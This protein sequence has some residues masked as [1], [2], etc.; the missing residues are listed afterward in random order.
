M[1]QFHFTDEFTDLEGQVSCPRS[2]SD[3]AQGLEPWALKFQSKGRVFIESEKCV[4]R[5]AQSNQVANNNK[6]ERERERN[7]LFPS[8]GPNTIK[9]SVFPKRLSS[10]KAIPRKH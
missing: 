5:D 8:R 6:K 1:V 7:K 10:F 3:Q 2:F 9:M 4:I